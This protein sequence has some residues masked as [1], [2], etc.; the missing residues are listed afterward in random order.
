MS[1]DFVPLRPCGVC[2][3]PCPGGRCSKPGHWKGG[4]RPRRPS[5]LTGT[6]GAG[7]RALVAA[8]LLAAARRCAYCDG[9]ANTGDHVVPHSKGGTSTHENVVAAC[10]WCNTSKGARTLK[11]WI[12]SGRAPAQA[13]RLMAER[14]VNELP[15]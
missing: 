3:Q 2:S 15:V 14:V 7:W 11:E 8:V 10:S 1:G 6:Y 13:A 5:V 4:Y 12:A 9:P